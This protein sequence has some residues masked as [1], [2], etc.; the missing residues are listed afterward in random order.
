MVMN[1]NRLPYT[2]HVYPR[3]VMNELGVVSVFNGSSKTK[4]YMAQ[5]GLAYGARKEPWM[6]PLNT[7]CVAPPWGYISGVDLRTQQVIWRR[8]LGTGYDQGPMGIPSKTKFEIGTPNNS[9]S[10]ATAG[11]VTFIG[12]SLDNFIRGF[13]TCT[14][15]QV[16]E[17]CV[18]AAR[19]PRR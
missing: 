17:T 2:E 10:L 12:A 14:G 9:G 7:P 4:G 19:R 6:S 1:S 11:G 15:K 3:T 5:E 16:W 8:P 13:D 18:P